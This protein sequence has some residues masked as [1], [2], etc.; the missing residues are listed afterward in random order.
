MKEVAGD[1]N[2]AFRTIAQGMNRGGLTK[3]AETT[4]A[5]D[6][7]KLAC[8][9]LYARRGQDLRAIGLTVE[10][11]VTMDPDGKHDNFSDYVKGM[12][13][14]DYAGEVEINLLAQNLKRPIFVYKKEG[15][16]YRRMAK[17]GNLVLLF[18]SNKKVN[19]YLIYGTLTDWS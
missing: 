8:K 1:G 10:Q 14:S 17:Y 16:F 5:K 7:R 15:S 11:L 18:I 2:C 3:D 6:L 9:E 19:V 4:R 13:R 12:A